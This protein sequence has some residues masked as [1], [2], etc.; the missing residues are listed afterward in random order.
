MPSRIFMT[1]VHRTLNLLAGF[2]FTLAATSFAQAQ[3]AKASLPARIELIPF[4]S[5]T[6]PDSA[7]LKGDKSA[8]A[9]NCVLK[10]E[11]PAPA[12]A[13]H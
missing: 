8:T 13:R 9:R 1:I 6:L 10:E 5:L 2:A 12:C 7:F 4:E 3:D 11:P